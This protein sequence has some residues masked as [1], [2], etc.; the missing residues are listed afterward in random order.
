MT[1][2]A[3]NSL[4]TV[5]YHTAEASPRLMMVLATSRPSDLDE[6]ILDRIDEMVELTAPDSAC[7]RDLCDVYFEKLLGEK[8][9]PRDVAFSEQK[10]KLLRSLAERSEGLSGND[11]RKIM[12]AVQAVVYGS[13]ECEL[14]EGIWR[15]VSERKLVEF[16]DKIHKKAKASQ[17]PESEKP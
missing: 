7:R 3:R 13:V 2:S 5:L 15:T 9:F 4:N 10:D 8:R 12:Q 1:E 11:I 6:A 16:K 14:T 17:N